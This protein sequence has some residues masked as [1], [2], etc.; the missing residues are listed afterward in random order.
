MMLKWLIAALIIY[1][2]ESWIAGEPSDAN[3]AIISTPA[4]LAV[5]TSR[6]KRP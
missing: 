5:L 2:G 3:W 6:T 4:N 1:G